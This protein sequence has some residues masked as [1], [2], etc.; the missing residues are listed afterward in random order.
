MRRQPLLH[1]QR[2]AGCRNCI[3]RFTVEILYKLLRSFVSLPQNSLWNMFLPWAI[4]S[5]CMCFNLRHQLHYRSHPEGE[6]VTPSS[7]HL[8][9]CFLLTKMPSQYCLL[10]NQKDDKHFFF[11]PSVEVNMIV[12]VHIIAI[13]DVTDPHPAFFESSVSHYIFSDDWLIGL[14]KHKWFIPL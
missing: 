9:E 13:F 12:Y 1:S 8:L 5:L 6:T 14:E 2:S 3:Y 10:W 7:T 11:R 4:L